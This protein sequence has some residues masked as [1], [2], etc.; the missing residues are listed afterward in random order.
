MAEDRACGADLIYKA[1]LVTQAS[2]GHGAAQ[3]ANRC[4]TQ[5]HL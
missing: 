3:G 5:C 2:V 1:G 4:G